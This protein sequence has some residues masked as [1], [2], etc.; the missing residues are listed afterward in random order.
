MGFGWP[1]KSGSHEFYQITHEQ[2]DYSPFRWEYPQAAQHAVKL[3]PQGGMALD[4]GAGHGNFAKQLPAGWRYFAVESTEVMR[5]R[6]E[7]R[8]HQTFETLELAAAKHPGEFS[9][10]VLF[11]ALEHVA[12]F[13]AMLP[14]LRKLARPGAVLAMSMPYGPDIR[15]RAAVSGCPDLP[16]NHINRW[17]PKGVE[18]AVARAGF[19]LESHVV[20]PATFKHVLYTA[21]LRTIA[22]AAQRP[23]SLSGRWY[24]IK[25]KKLRIA[26]APALGAIHLARMA[27]RLGHA[28]LT[29][30]FLTL[31][32]AV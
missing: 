1:H 23:R 13:D 20:Q 5:Q 27:P 28:A 12:E 11:Q 3:F 2:A 29:A 10:I 14:L 32:R 30:N 9:L 8:G 21:Y 4:V 24:A 7:A 6:L 16:P 17:T 22:E 25:N 15:R 19:T 26:V 18:A 31:S